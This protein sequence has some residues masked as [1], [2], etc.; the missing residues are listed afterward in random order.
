MRARDSDRNETCQLL[1][2]A[3]AEGQ[4]S[5]E[6][7]RNRISAATNAATL[8]ELESLVSDLQATSTPANARHTG[9][10]SP[11]GRLVTAVVVATAAAISIAVAVAVFTNSEPAPSQ[12]GSAAP[13]P[14][15]PISVA[16]K[17][18]TDPGAAPDDVAPSV[19]NVPKQLQT[20]GGMT[21]VLDQMRKR[22]G[23]TTGIELAITPDEAMLFRPDPTDEKSKLLYRFNGGWG[24]PTKR[25][26][27]DKDTPADLGAF[28]VK[29]VAEV[30]RLAPETLGIP[31]DD[32]G[33]VWVDIDNMADPA[34]PPA[35]ELLVKVE[36][37]SGGDG[38]IYLNPAG[39]T[40]R[41]EYPG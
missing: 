37:K 7:H 26:R 27:D 18:P 30:L 9:R 20:L 16:P 6:E 32:V 36:K 19:L 25:P 17:K 1:D 15:A 34:G 2:G 12:P 10:L 3:L 29:A 24:D 5:M 39:N 22:F 38:F 21:A 40:K 35:L 4:L 23:D 33:E 41:V 8:G 31:P 13:V 14:E 11:R 28:D